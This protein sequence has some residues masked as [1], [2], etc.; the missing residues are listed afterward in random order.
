MKFDAE[1]KE[2]VLSLPVSEKDKLLLRL[3]K[4][5]LNLVNRLHF[6]LVDNRTVDERRNLL[7]DRII[8]NTERMKENYWSPGY[9]MMDMRYLS[10]EITDHVRIAK[11]KFGEVSLTILMLSEVLKKTNA[12][13]EKAVPAKR[14]KYNMYVIARAFKILVLIKKLHEDYMLDIKEPLANLGHLIGENHGLMKTA[15]NNGLDVNWLLGFDIPENIAEQQKELR[16]NG[17]LK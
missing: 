16:A 7:E 9:L 8:E 17:F 2:A 5:D 15:I 11:D 1:F 3:L 13:V 10:G 4:K 6:E 12:L 14:R